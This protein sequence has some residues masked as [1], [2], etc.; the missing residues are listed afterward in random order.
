[1]AEDLRPG[2]RGAA[3][4]AG[5]EGDTRLRILDAAIACFTRYGNEKTTLNDVARV[6][7][8]ARQ[9]IYRYFPDRAAVLEGV[10][11]LEDR[12]LRADVEL[13]AGQSTSFEEFLAALVE[14]RSVTVSRYHTRQ[15][16]LDLDLGLVHSLHLSRDHNVGLIRELIAPQ[17]DLARVRGELLPDVDTAQAS[18]WVA[19]ALSTVTTL[20]GAATF[21]V[22]NSA[23]VGRFYARHICRGLVA[24]PAVPG[25]TGLERTP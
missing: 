24:S 2:V 10:Q 16:L 23:E 5:R 11:D 22:E 1:M 3:G 13:I 9:T 6:A 4:D 25:A 15:H 12:R 20:T 14:E 7:G 21:D 8:L 18:E 17:L 19:I